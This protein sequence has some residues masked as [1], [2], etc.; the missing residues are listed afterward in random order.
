MSKEKKKVEPGRA[1]ENA[2]GEKEKGKEKLIH[3]AKRK[4]A[5]LMM[6]GPH[7]DVGRNA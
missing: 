1:G 5:R 4:K 6:A 7:V 2:K 3:T